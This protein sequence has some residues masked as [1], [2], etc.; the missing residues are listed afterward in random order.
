MDSITYIPYAD[1]I[2][3]IN[4]VKSKGLA[5]DELNVLRK[6]YPQISG[7]AYDSMI[8]NQLAKLEEYMLKETIRIFQ[9]QMNNC[10][11]EN[12]LEILNPA[13]TRLR[14]HIVNCLFFLQIP[15]YPESVKTEMGNEIK[16][17]VDSFMNVF[18]KYLK[19]IEHAENNDFIQEYVYICRNRIKKIRKIY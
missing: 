16:K 2:S 17:N 4:A 15:D 19:K 12:D 3:L 9:K 1:W 14:K 7:M 18:L 10:L 13:F 6:V 11:E 8:C 5:C